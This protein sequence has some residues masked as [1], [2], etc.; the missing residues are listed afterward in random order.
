MTITGPVESAPLPQI[1]D[2]V[3]GGHSY[4]A[5]TLVTRTVTVA[6]PANQ[7]D[8]QVAL[9]TGAVE[10]MSFTLSSLTG[11]NGLFVT[12]SGGGGYQLIG[13]L[14]AGQA[15]VL[16]QGYG[17]GY[18]FNDPT[19]PAKTIHLYTGAAV[20]AGTKLTASV[21]YYAPP[22]ALAGSA[23]YL[24]LD[25][26]GVHTDVWANATGTGAVA[27][28][29]VRANL[30]ALAFTGTAAANTVTVDFSAG[31]PLPAGGLTTGRHVGGGRGHG[32]RHGRQRHG[33]GDRDHP[34]RRRRVVRDG[35]D[36]RRE[37]VQRSPSGATAGATR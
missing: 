32:R 15:D 21:T 30:S 22:T 20:A 3:T 2:L 4:A 6:V 16:P 33:D 5:A 1:A 12:N 31:N 7:S 36:H 13:S 27:Q 37:H 28:S 18:P 35:H 25:A 29:L 26:D 17:T 19:A 9:C 14:V 24:K 8:D 34:G 23:V 11:V 10:T